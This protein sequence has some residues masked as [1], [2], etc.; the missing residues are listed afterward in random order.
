[1]LATMVA[2]SAKPNAARMM[3]SSLV[4]WSFCRMIAATI[5]PTRLPSTPAAVA[6]PNPRWIPRMRPETT[7][8]PR[9]KTT[10]Q[11]VL[12][13]DSSIVMAIA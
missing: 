3:F 12:Q 11:T 6:R 2:S 5:T 8:T 10:V 13:N 4:S 9:T 7:P 1:M